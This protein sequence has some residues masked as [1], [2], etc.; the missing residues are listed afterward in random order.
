MV[1]LPTMWSTD[2]H[3][4]TVPPDDAQLPTMWN[5]DIHDLTVP[6]DG[7]ASYNVEHIQT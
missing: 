6:P 5:T 1:L 3:D 2:R 7:A 4:L